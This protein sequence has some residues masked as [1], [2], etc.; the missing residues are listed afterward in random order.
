MVSL[1]AQAICFL[2]TRTPAGKK[3]ETELFTPCCAVFLKKARGRSMSVGHDD[4]EASPR[5]LRQHGFQHLTKQVIADPIGAAVELLRLAFCKAVEIHAVV[6]PP[7]N[8]LVP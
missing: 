8:H 1:D 3:L 6:V 5:K 4:F 7:A 2:R